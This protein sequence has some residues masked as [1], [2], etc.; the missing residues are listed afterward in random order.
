MGLET[1]QRKENQSRKHI[2]NSNNEYKD[3]KEKN[4]WYESGRYPSMDYGR[5][6]RKRR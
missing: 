4:I 3:L 6:W 5:R 2:F 1:I